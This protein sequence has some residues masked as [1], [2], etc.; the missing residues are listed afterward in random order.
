MPVLPPPHLRTPMHTTHNFLKPTIAKCIV[1]VNSFVASI[2]LGNLTVV[3]ETFA[4][5]TL[6]IS[7]FSIAE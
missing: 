7:I 3:Q 1:N 5:S 2:C 6:I 4:E